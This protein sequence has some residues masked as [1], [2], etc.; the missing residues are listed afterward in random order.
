VG[1]RSETVTRSPIRHC[2]VV[3]GL[4]LTFDASLLAAQAQTNATVDALSRWV[5]AVNEHAPGTPDAS[6]AT[7]AAMRYSARVQLNMSFPL[8]IRALRERDGVATDSVFENAIRSLAH[9]VRQAPGTATFLERAAVLH[10]D[11]LIFANRFPA[12][13]DDVPSMPPSDSNP[14]VRTNLRADTTPPLLTNRRVT[15][16]RDGQVLGDAPADWNLPF[17]RSLLDEL[18]RGMPL[19]EERAF[20]GEWYHAIAAYL[21]AAGKNGDATGH[22]Q[23]AERVLPDDARLL[24]DRGTHAE[25]LGLPIY[26]A[27]HDT[28]ASSAN[29]ISSLPSEDKMNGDAERLYRRALE[30]DPSY[31]EA[32]VRLARLLQHRGQLDAA[33]AQIARALDAAPTGAVGYYTHV[34]AGRIASAGSRYDEALRQYRAALNLYGDAQ[35]ALLGASHAALM[36]AEV[37]ATLTPLERLGGNHAADSDPWWEYRLGAGR[38]VNQLMAELWARVGK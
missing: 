22:L 27:V 36:L 28:V 26:Q 6:V 3:F 21:L 31:V 24:F 12:P 29:L 23:Q 30:V 16:V 5:K 14:R 10:S 35:S 38:D 15:L 25:T 37:S 18:L 11:T 19:P 33:A 4:L 8:F 1:A 32:R 2:F 20:V 13:P 34:V 17:A 7:T 9:S